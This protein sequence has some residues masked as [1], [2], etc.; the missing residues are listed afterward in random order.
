MGKALSDEQLARYR[1][2]GYL[3][4]PSFFGADALTLIDKTIREL[5]D[6]AL[7]GGDYSKVLELE[8][9]ASDDRR[10]ARRIFSPYDQHDEFKA[11]AHDERLLDTVEAL[12]GPDITLQHSKLN[13]KPPRVGSGV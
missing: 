6:R 8:P 11:L 7:A 10:V 1:T 12:I 5:T 2:D 9:E 3:V 4:L 13:M